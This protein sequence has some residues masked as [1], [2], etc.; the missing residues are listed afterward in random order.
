MV[1]KIAI[2][3]KELK[4]GKE[5]TLFGKFMLKM[6]PLY[7]NKPPIEILPLDIKDILFHEFQKI[8]LSCIFRRREKD[9]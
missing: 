7:A 6:K 2:V 3:D 4:P 9:G 5:K 1:Q 8:T